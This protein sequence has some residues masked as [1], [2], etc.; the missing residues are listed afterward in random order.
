[1][2][3]DML[4]NASLVANVYKNCQG[5]AFGVWPNPSRII[6]NATGGLCEQ[7]FLIKRYYLLSKNLPF[8][9]IL[10]IISLAHGACHLTSAGIWFSNAKT[11]LKLVGPGIHVDIHVAGWCLGLVVD[12]LVTVGIVWQLLQLNAVFKSTKG[13]VRQFLLTTVVTGGL[14]VICALLLLI[15]LKQTKY[16]Y[17]VF[18]TNM[19]KIYVITVFTNLAVTHGLLEQPSGSS[20]TVSSLGKGRLTSSLLAAFRF[21]RVPETKDSE[22]DSAA[23]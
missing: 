10:V 11:P 19:E 22:K 20:R 12:I 23:T 13:M 1:M 15:L 5:Y 17:L 9:I 2:A 21:P 4:N 6:A 14:T 8:T 18:A 7:L 3:N 16:A